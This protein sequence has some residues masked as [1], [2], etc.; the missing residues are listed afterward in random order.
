[1]GYVVNLCFVVSLITCFWTEY[2]SSRGCGKG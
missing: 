2:G 1:V